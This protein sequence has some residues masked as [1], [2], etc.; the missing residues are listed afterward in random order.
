[1]KVSYLPVLQVLRELYAQ[2]RDMHRF[3]E[4]IARMTGGGDDLVLPIG[5]ANPMAREQALARVDEL[6]AMGADQAGAEAAHEAERRLKA[7][8]TVE[9]K[10]AIVLAD[11]VA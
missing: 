4:Y 6:L 5:A 1:M 7:V 11:D 2:P 3:R 9:I 10:A 8:Q